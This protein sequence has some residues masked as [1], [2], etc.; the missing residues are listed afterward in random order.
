V[1]DLYVILYDNILKNPTTKHGREG[2]YFG[3][4]GEHR[5]YD[6][7]KKSAEALAALGKGKSPE[8]TKFSEEEVK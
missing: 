1:A 6:I 7:Y 4:S 5:L 2:F 3:E 8:P